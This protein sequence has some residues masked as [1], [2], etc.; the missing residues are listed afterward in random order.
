MQNESLN[1]MFSLDD[2]AQ[3]ESADIINRNG[4][5]SAMR[6]L[7]KFS[8]GSEAKIATKIGTLLKK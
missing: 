8:S 2:G 4:R 6:M 7:R 3:T 5:P 1:S